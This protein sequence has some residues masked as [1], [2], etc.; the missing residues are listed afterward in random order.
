MVRYKYDV[1]ANLSLNLIFS[2]TLFQVS[3]CHAVI[4]RSM[5]RE[6]CKQCTTC[7]L[8]AVQNVRP[9]LKPIITKGFMERIQVNIVQLNA[10]G[11]N[12]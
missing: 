2:C 9:P 7:A 8:K 10:K 1:T 12:E 11:N 6:F 3:E 5:V 4:S